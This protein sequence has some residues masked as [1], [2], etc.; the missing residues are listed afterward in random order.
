MAE[1]TYTITVTERQARIISN[2][3]ELMARIGFGQWM[4][5]LNYLP[6]ANELNWNEMREGLLPIME[7]HLKPVVGINGWSSSL[8]VGS[9]KSAPG[10]DEAF[11]LNAV[12]RHRLAWDRAMDNGITDGT[13]RNW[14]GMMSV[15]YDDP[16]HWGKE[17]LARIEAVKQEDA[18]GPLD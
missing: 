11:D 4:E 6:G 13:T 10:T 3:C 14:T 8:G 18:G 17:P 16:M 2:A 1:R 15:D 7:R 12:I 5:F 9:D